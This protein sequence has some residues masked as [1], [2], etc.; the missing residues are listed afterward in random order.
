MFYCEEPF[1]PR[2][3]QRVDKRKKRVFDHLNDDAT[4]NRCENLCFA[5]SICN[6]QKKYKPFWVAKAKKQ[7][8]ENVRD[9]NIETISHGGSDKETGTEID[10]NAIYY[11]IAI[12]YLKDN[13]NPQGR[14]FFYPIPKNIY[15]EK[16]GKP[17]LDEKDNPV[18][19]HDGWWVV[20]WAKDRD[21]INNIVLQASQSLQNHIE[22]ILNHK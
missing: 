10:T 20:L 14:I 12:K 15:F 21:T 22:D 16:C 7:L 11:E 18:H 2:I 13:L 5:H 8:K 17:V 4:D 19:T 1:P 6:E 3:I 9:A